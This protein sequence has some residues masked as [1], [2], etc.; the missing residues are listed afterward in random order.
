[1]YKGMDKILK[2]REHQPPKSVIV[3][4]L[5]TTTEESAKNIKIEY[6]YDTDDEEEDHLKE[7][8]HTL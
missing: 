4:F 5:L 8:I 7:K 2:R 6:N 1:M 3:L